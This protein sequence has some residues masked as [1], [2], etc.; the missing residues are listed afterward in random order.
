MTVFRLDVHSNRGRGRAW[1]SM[2]PQWVIL[3]DMPFPPRVYA[4]PACI[5]LIFM[6]IWERNG[7]TMLVKDLSSAI[8]RSFYSTSAQKHRFNVSFAAV[9]A[10]T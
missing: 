10:T 2:G 7:S 4:E 8:L 6:D 5:L 3:A 9:T 1:A